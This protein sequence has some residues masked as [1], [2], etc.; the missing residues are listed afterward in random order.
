MYALY[1]RAGN[2][3]NLRAKRKN[4]FDKISTDN[5]GNTAGIRN[6]IMDMSQ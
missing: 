3:R 5:T 2:F 1:D 4:T 6:V